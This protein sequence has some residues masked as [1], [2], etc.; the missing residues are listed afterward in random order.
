MLYFAYGANMN[1]KSMLSRCPTAK[2]MGLG[3]IPNYQ[4]IIME[5]GYATIIPKKACL[6]FNI[7][8]NWTT[9]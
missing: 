7:N 6:Y 8:K 5:H 4:F 9:F 3:Y 1:K 2:Y